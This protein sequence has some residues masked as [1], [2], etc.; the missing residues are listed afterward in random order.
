VKRA[1]K[2]AAKV[3]T[4]SG[5]N[6][7]RAKQPVLDGMTPPSQ[8]TRRDGTVLLLAHVSGDDPETCALCD[9]DWD[10]CECCDDCGE[11][12]RN[13]ECDTTTGAL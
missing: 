8:I 3:A 10:A 7:R 5:P 1:T 9:L 4:Y 13:C 11:P 12:P 6:G 2:R